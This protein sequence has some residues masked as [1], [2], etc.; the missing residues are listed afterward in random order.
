M[1]ENDLQ[2][3]RID[4]GEI[5]YKQMIRN[6]RNDLLKNTDKYLLPDYPITED[7]IP[8]IKTYRQA[9]RDIS[10]NNFV[11]PTPPDFIS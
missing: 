8:I 7:Q 6:Q 3:K 2:Q 5:F 10:E 1:D 11:L 9:L 4:D